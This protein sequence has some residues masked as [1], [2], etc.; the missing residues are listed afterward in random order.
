MKASE[1][2]EKFPKIADIFVRYT[3]F[4]EEEPDTSEDLLHNLHSFA[5]RERAYHLGGHSEQEAYDKYKKKV[6][7]RN[8]DGPHPLDDE[9][10]D[11]TKEIMQ[12]EGGFASGSRSNSTS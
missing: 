9:V 11:V 5:N 2:M 12:V 10:D 8:Y 3:K 7:D 6:A 1:F 4:N